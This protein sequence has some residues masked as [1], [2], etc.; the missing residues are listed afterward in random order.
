MDKQF[1]IY[2]GI[3]T[4]KKVNGLQITNTDM[5]DSQKYSWA[6]EAK[7]KENTV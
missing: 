6:K 3:F 1:V 7:I 5:D 2:Y 4:I